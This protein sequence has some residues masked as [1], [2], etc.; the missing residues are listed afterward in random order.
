MSYTEAKS[1]A[2]QFLAEEHLIFV[3]A[4]EAEMLIANVNAAP[5]TIPVMVFNYGAKTQEGSA[6][7]VLEELPP[8]RGQFTG[9]VISA[10]V[11]EDRARGKFVF[12]DGT[13]IHMNSS[14]VA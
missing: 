14:F 5:V 10:A 8:V 1:K 2:E 9:S 6:G 7:A 11:D 12:S 4:D 13:I 3:S